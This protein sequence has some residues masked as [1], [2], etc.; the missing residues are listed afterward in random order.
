MPRMQWQGE[1]VDALETRFK[2]VREDWNEYELEDGTIIRMKPVVAEVLRI[3]DHWDTEGNP[4]YQVKSA[5]VLMV[6]A[7][8]HL[9]KGYARA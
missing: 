3:V 5:N 7:P 2:V 6:K 9:K 8:D 4:V 1:E